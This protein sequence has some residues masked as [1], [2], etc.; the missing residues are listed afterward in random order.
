MKTLHIARLRTGTVYKLVF[1]GLLAGFFPIFLLFGILGS[2]DMASLSWNEQPV[3]GLKA[4]LIG[5][6][7]GVFMALLFTALIG[8]VM[9]LGLWL[10]SR[11]KPLSIEYE[12]VDGD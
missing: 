2:M 5:P 11:F 12:E 6:L 9:A 4:I 10:Y 1:T 8:S 7:M 3:T